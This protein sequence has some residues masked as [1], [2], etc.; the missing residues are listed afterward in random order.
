MGVPVQLTTQVVHAFFDAGQTSTARHLNKTST[1]VLKI[2]LNLLPKVQG[3]GYPPGL[4]VLVGV[5]EGFPQQA[6]EG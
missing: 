6:K 1:V 3:Q 4:G 5:M 2:Y